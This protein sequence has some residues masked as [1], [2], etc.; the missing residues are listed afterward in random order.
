MNLRPSGYEPDELPGCSIP[1]RLWRLFGYRCLISFR[2]I[3]VFIRFGGDL[4]SHDL[5]RS[6]IGANVLNGRVRD[7]IGCFTIAVT[8]K[9]NKYPS[10]LL[11]EHQVKFLYV[12]AFDM[13]VNFAFT[14]SN[15][16]YRAI[17]TGQL[18]ALLHLHLRP[19]DEVVY[20]GSQGYL[21]LR[22]ASRLDA[23]SG[24]PFRS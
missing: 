5:S 3:W 22:G 8:T 14:G 1:R 15:Q 24:Y 13:S 6:T 21:V 4:L 17:S 9:P 20:L 11:G 19:I 7:G 18:N 23:F 2:E 10:S 16:A 12:Y